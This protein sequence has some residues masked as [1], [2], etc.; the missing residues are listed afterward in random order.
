[1]PPISPRDPV[2]LKFVLPSRNASTGGESVNATVALEY[3]GL[4]PE[5]EV[6]GLQ[7]HSHSLS[8]LLY[9]GSTASVIYST[10]KL[11]PQSLRIMYIESLPFLQRVP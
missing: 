10:P 2:T 8:V 9:F 5:C 3:V 7:F 11:L 6:L 4:T 1:M